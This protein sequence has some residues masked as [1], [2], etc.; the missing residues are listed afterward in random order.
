MD[1]SELVKIFDPANPGQPTLIVPGNFNPAA[2]HLR[3]EYRPTAQTADWPTF[4]REALQVPAA[5]DSAEP[6]A[7]GDHAQ[8]LE[9]IDGIATALERFNIR[10]VE[11]LARAGMIAGVNSDLAAKLIAWARAH[12]QL[13][14]GTVVEPAT[15][16]EKPAK[17]AEREPEPTLNGDGDQVPAQDPAA[18]E[19]TSKEQTLGEPESSDAA[20]EAPKHHGER[21]P[22]R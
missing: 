14:A 18:G 22:R 15:E 4:V 16:P 2:G 6:E 10:T 20:E 9:K 3:W 7:L 11:D 1:R 5:I 21:K 17:E 8:R 12:P 19:Q 13:P